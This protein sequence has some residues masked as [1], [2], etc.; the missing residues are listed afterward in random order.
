MS[1]RNIAPKCPIC[2]AF[3]TPTASQE[4]G[5]QEEINYYCKELTKYDR[6]N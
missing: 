3:L 5:G 6:P 4:Y 1:N 2:G